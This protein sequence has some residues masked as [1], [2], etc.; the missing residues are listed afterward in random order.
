M[1]SDQ[2][3]ITMLSDFRPKDGLVTLTQG[4]EL[5]VDSTTAAGLVLYGVAARRSTR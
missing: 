3:A 5:S 2:V 1:P 4:T